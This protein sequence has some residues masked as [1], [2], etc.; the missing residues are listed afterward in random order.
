MAPVEEHGS[1]LVFD[2]MTSDWSVLS[3]ADTEAPYPEARSYHCLASDGRDTIYLHAGCPE[4]GRLSDLWSFQLSKRVW[5]QLASAPDPARGGTSI[6]FTQGT[7]FR[8]H[9]FD[10][11]TE[12]GGSL[13]LY[14][15]NNDSW[16][17]VKYS[18]DGKSGPI[19]SSVSTLLP[20]TVKGRASLVTLFGELDPSA[21]GHAGAGKMSDYI[22]KY[23]IE[24]KKWSQIRIHADDKPAP[25]GWFAADT[26]GEGKVVVHGGLDEDNGRLGDIWIVDLS[27]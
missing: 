20:I 13:D 3:P 15:P 19:P 4:K 26:V 22:W 10:G 7:L 25:R 17:S 16:S 27:S 12:Q 11:K 6:T 2:P 18:P 21:L 14:D 8:M 5:T 1:L 23:D 9:G 24:D